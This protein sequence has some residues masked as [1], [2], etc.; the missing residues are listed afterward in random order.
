VDA[1][2]ESSELRATV[3][4]ALAHDFK[5]PLTSMKAASAGL[6][7]SDA[8]NTVGR[9]LAT[10]IDEDVDRLQRLLTDA[11]HMLREVCHTEVV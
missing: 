3:L 1:A 8:L 9:E 4:D 11:A 2:R 6:L 7:A 5:T 10:I